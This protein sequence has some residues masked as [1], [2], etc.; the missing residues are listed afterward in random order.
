MRDDDLPL[1]S[2][3]PPCK[4]ILFPLVKRVGKVRHTAQ[5]L[6]SK[7]GEDAILYWKQV[8]AA[9]RKHLTRIGLDQDD[10]E[11]ELGSFHEAVHS[12]MVRLAYCGGR[13]NGGAA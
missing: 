11:A 1:L 8:M 6:S 5:L 12:E 10:I 3:T 13:G 4:V 9:N 7:H 2:W